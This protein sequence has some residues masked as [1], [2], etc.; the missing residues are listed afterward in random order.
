M[1]QIT[2]IKNGIVLDHIKPGVGVKIFEYL[3]LSEV[4]GEVALIINATSKKNGK[5]DIIKIEEIDDVNNTVLAVL[6]P[7]I[8]IN[9]VRNQEIVEKIKPQLPKIVENIIVCKNP[10]C[11]TND[12]KYLSQVFKL[13]NEE[14]GSYKCDYCE[15]VIKPSEV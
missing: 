13:F 3:N 4:E 5:K 9:K 7:G 15:N 6:S 12:E 11:I 8:T 1:L 2:S 10:A 14:V